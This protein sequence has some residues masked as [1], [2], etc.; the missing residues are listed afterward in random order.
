MKGIKIMERNFEAPE[1][2]VVVFENEDVITASGSSGGAF[3]D[4]YMD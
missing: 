1:L 4:G 2:E 3:D